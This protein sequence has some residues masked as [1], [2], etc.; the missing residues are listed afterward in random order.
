MLACRKDEPAAP[1]PSKPAATTITTAT[2]VPAPRPLDA[3]V[4]L[5]DLLRAVPTT[6]TVSSTVKNPA[7]LPAHLVDHDLD[8]AWNAATGELARSW[9]EIALPPGAASVEIRMTVGH[10]G[11][12]KHG[13]D[14]FTM[15]PRL[16][17]VSV[18]SGDKF[19]AKAPL[20][21]TKRELQAVPAKATGSVRIEVDEIIPGSMKAWRETSVSELEVWG[22]PPPGWTAPAKPLVPTVVVQPP[23]TPPPS[24]DPCAW[25]A[26]EQAAKERADKATAE[27]CKENPSPNCGLDM[28]GGAA[29]GTDITKLSLAAPWN[30]NATVTC[31]THDS[32]YGEGTC[33]IA[34]GP[35]SLE[36]TNNRPT[37]DIDKLTATPK[38]IAGT[39]VLVLRYTAGSTDWIVACRAEPAGCTSPDAVEQPDVPDEKALT[40]PL[41]F[42]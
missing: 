17:S 25:L 31:F 19:L 8:T 18:W 20:D 41:V 23:P 34:I 28:P 16:K 29:C 9:I 6:I 22:V 11:H 5:V 42:K 35:V 4:A 33:D 12:G 30:T 38:T 39:A 27:G 1:A 24:N 15:N 40:L 10:T 21:I 14:Y 37:M 2:A 7:I 32:H 26:E 36:V 3:A 13:E